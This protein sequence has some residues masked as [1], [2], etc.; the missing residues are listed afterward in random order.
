MRCLSLQ[1]VWI[2]IFESNG[3][4]RLQKQDSTNTNPYQSPAAELATVA[5]TEPKSIWFR[6]FYWGRWL[7]LIPLVVIAFFTVSLFTIFAADSR[8][9]WYEPVVGVVASSVVVL[10]AFIVPPD[11]K[12]LCATVALVLG[13][14][15]AWI[16]IQPPSTN[17]S[18]VNNDQLNYTYTSIIA[19]YFSGAVSWCFCYFWHRR[20]KPNSNAV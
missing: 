10:V 19:T 6:V 11:M 12:I 20:S 14:V 4:K 8:G 3:N 18:G 9:I 1:A 7:S 16:L 13:A 15:V 5:K 2:K 17:Y